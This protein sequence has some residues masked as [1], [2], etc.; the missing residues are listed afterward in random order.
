M[1][2]PLQVDV[3]AVVL[4]LSIP[5]GSPEPPPGSVEGAMADKHITISGQRTWASPGAAAADVVEVA[6]VGAPAPVAVRHRRWVYDCPGN[7]W[8]ADPAMNVS[9]EAA[10]QSCAAS[11]SQRAYLAWVATGPPGEPPAPGAAWRIESGSRGCLDPATAVEDGSGGAAVPVVTVEDLRR[12]PLPPATAHVLK[13]AGQVL[14][15]VPTIVHAEA[16]PAT[17][18]L[19]LLDQPVTVEATPASF[20]W[21]FG[22]DSPPLATTDPGQPYPDHTLTHTYRQAGPFDI[23]LATT[24][25]GRYAVA[26]GPW[27]PIDG[28]ATTTSTP[29]SLTVVEARARLI[30]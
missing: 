25:T 7:G 9:C 23:T 12:L 30:G 20:T 4:A 6:Q 21:D 5:L 13:G 22:D 16:P 14:I 28:T 18:E 10:I 1:T 27:Q 2:S 29:E 8:H 24:W 19:T 3:A 11:P 17:F 26:G 15:H